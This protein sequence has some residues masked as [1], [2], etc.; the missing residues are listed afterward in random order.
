[1]KATELLLQYTATFRSA[2]LE[3]KILKMHTEQRFHFANVEKDRRLSKVQGG[4]NTNTS[5][6]FDIF[7]FFMTLYSSLLTL[8]VH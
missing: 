3:V 7:I 2:I 8:Q 4:I 5:H 6:T 1:M